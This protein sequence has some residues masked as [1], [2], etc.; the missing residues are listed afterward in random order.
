MVLYAPV[1]TPSMYVIT[2]VLGKTCFI[3]DLTEKYYITH[4][5]KQYYPVTSTS[6]IGGDL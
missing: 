1:E 2:L 4:S 5:A 6:V 3:R